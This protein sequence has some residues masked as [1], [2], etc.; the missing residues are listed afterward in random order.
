VLEVAES[1]YTGWYGGDDVTTSDVLFA[2]EGNPDATV[3]GDLTTG[4]GSPRRPTTA[5]SARRRCR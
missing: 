3:I 1:T 5:S 2:A 4:A